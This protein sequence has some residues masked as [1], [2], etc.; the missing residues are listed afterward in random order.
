MAKIALFLPNLFGGGAERCFVNLAKGLA[1]CGHDVDLVVS[2]KVGPY[3]SEVAPNVKLV[4]LNARVPL[5]SFPQ[6]A[7]YLKKNRPDILYSALNQA[8]VAAIIASKL[9]GTKVPVVI[10]VHNSLSMEAKNATGINLKM[11]PIFVKRFYPMADEIVAV[12]A[13][14]ADDLTQLTRI[15]RERITVIYNPVVSDELFSKALEPV[16]HPWF[17]PDQPPVVL[18]VGRLNGQKDYGTLIRAFSK[19]SKK[20]PARLIILGDGPERPS[21]TALIEELGLSDKISIPGFVDNPYAY[22]NK[23]AL[24]VL[25]SIYEGLPTVLIETLAVGCPVVSTDCPS[26]PR[27]I[28]QDGKLGTLVPVGDVEALADA[29]EA[30]LAKPRTT[31][32]SET[33]EQFSLATATR[34]YESFINSASKAPLDNITTVGR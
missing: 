20:R 1:D 28:L 8:N 13:G 30:A 7:G 31:M 6:L 22:M 23:S 19:L 15:P 12:S 9:S 33:W 26:G 3:V 18:A 5:L 34:Q 21:L 32:P 27:E 17:E 4:D 2:R 16:Q 10:G 14:V 29:M 11:M 25:S 24:F